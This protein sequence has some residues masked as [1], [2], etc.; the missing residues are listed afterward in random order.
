M[1]TNANDVHFL[2]HKLCTERTACVL[3]G[4]ELLPHPKHQ[5]PL[6]KT[7]HLLGSSLL[8]TQLQNIQMQKQIQKKP[9][10]GLLTVPH[11]LI[12]PTFPFGATKL[13]NTQNMTSV[14]RMQ[15]ELPLAVATQSRGLHPHHMA[16]TRKN[17]S[18]RLTFASPLTL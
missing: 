2:V 11:T 9:T 7:F 14:Y 6:H 15:L 8:H 17:A 12:W 16:Y 1:N 5:L 13:L 3:G 10:I 18:K 4:G